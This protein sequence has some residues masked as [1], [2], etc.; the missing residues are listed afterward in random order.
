MHAVGKLAKYIKPYMWFAILAPLLMVF[1]VAMDLVQPMIF[2]RIIDEGIANNDTAY[3]LKMFG[4]NILAAIGGLIGGVGCGIYASK[5][6]VNFA[7]DV[8]ADLYE[9][10]TYF[11]IVV[12][13][14][15]RLEN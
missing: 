8:R 14:S 13:I 2:Q 12:K 9:T 15:L 5:T 1:E 4:W 6:A 11:Q 7:T 3:I 10:I